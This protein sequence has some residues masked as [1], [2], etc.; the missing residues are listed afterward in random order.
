MTA[1]A[2]GNVGT[3]VAGMNTIRKSFV[4]HMARFAASATSQTILQP[5]VVVVGT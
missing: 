5:S 1:N 4:E 2:L 3:V